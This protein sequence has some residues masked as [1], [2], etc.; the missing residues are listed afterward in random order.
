MQMS[1]WAWAGL[2]GAGAAVGAAA[3]AA[4]DWMRDTRRAG[5]DD[6]REIRDL[7]KRQ[8]TQL[9]ARLEKEESQVDSLRAENATLQGKVAQLEAAVAVALQ[10]KQALENA[11]SQLHETVEALRERVRILEQGG[12][13]E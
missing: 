6:D 8:V 13:S 2:A 11:V 10:E 1:E 5:Y 12:D 3:K 9:L 4:F 7:W